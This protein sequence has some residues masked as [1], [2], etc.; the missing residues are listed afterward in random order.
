MVI[1]VSWNQFR[2]AGGLPEVLLDCN[3]LGLQS[4]ALAAQ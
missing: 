2:V 4:A 3:L 1:A